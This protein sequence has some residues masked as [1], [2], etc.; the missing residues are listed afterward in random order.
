[1]FREVV[2]LITL[3][4]AQCPG[5]QAGDKESKAGVIHPGLQ[6]GAWPDARYLHG[7]RYQL[8]TLVWPSLEELVR[9]ESYLWGLC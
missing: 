9:G 1:M 4:L 3:G 7:V 5:R 6:N 8:H 2:R